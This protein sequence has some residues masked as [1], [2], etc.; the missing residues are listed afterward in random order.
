MRIVQKPRLYQLFKIAGTLLQLLSKKREG[1]SRLQM[2]K[3][4]IFIVKPAVHALQAVD[5]ALGE[6][7]KIRLPVFK[8]RTVDARKQRLFIDSVHSHSCERLPDNLQKTFL[9]RLVGIF[10]HHGKD[11]LVSRIVI[12]ADDIL[13]DTRIQ[14][15]L[16]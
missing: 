13:S 8:L 14:K 11:G 12:G 7:A 3:R 16:L 1:L 2:Q 5:Q 6:T 9:V 4:L 10:C 15:R